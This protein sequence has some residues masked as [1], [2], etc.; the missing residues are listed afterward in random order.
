LAEDVN[1]R[2]VG[3]A[4]VEALLD[5]NVEDS[6]AEA[7]L[8]ALQSLVEAGGPSAVEA[9]GGGLT[10]VIFSIPRARGLNPHNDRFLLRALESG[11]SS[12][13][14]S[15][16]RIRALVCLLSHYAFHNNRDLVDESLARF[17]DPNS[18]SGWA[19]LVVAYRT[20]SELALMPDAGSRIGAIIQY[21]STPYAGT[22]GAAA[23]EAARRAA[24]D[25]LLSRPELEVHPRIFFPLL[26]I[27]SDG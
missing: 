9:F 21:V 2:N 8:S 6:K 24:V 4:F 19:G 18:A 10:N 17:A 13:E 7:L 14:E 11:I 5:E 20:I 12:P 23:V 1:W 22:E 15:Q 27:S 26:G 25:S 16:V 3:F